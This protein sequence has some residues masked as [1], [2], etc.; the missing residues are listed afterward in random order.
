MLRNLGPTRFISSQNSAPQKILSSAHPS[1]APLIRPPVSRVQSEI[2]ADS[3]IKPISQRDRKS[4]LVISKKS[5][6]ICIDEMN[7]KRNTN[8]TPIITVT[9]PAKNLITSEVT[10]RL[11]YLLRVNIRNSF[12]FTL[13]I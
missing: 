4:H 7:S 12:L 6:E 1:A 11:F 3:K 2:I 8:D 5:V 10:Y 13:D 9:E